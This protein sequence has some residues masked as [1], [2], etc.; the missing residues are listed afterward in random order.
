MASFRGHLVT[1]AGLG[2]IYGGAAYWRLGFDPI[3][4]AI[5]AG[6]TAVG[7]LLPDLD[8]D[9]SVPNRILFRLAAVAAVI[10]TFQYL[11][12]TYY[13]I[14]EG[15]VILAAAYLAVRYVLATGFRFITVHR[16]MFHS[17]PAMLIVGLSLYL[18]YGNYVERDR[19]FMAGA[20]MLGFLSHLV[21]DEI[22]AVDF[23]GARLKKPFGSALKLYS[24]SWSA[25][26]FCYGTLITLGLLA[27]SV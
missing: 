20:G 17:I 7:G 14:M 19:L 18:L 15:A 27:W 10:V 4:A 1:A 2:V 25:T 13:P 26:T 11:L 8:S 23:Q 6:I 5:A 22:C 9:S 24:S 12:T 16:G 21:L 3:L